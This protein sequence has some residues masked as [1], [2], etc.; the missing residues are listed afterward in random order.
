MVLMAAIITLLSAGFGYLNYLFL[1]AKITRNEITCLQSL[2]LSRL[3]LYLF[4]AIEHSIIIVCGISLGT[5]SGYQISDLM[6]SPLAVNDSGTKIIPRFILDTDWGIM[7][8]WYVILTA[9]FVLSGILLTRFIA[10]MDINQS[11]RIDGV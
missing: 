1:F 4:M 3:Q 8:P 6:V 2:G 5:W 7:G 9:F 10:K 11:T